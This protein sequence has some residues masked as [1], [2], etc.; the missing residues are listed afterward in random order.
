LNVLLVTL[1]TTRADHIQ[2]YGRRSA[3][4]PNLDRLAREGILFD[5]AASVAPLTVPAHASLLT[6]VLP[7]THGIRDNLDVLND[8]RQ[9]SLG[10][11]LKPHGFQTAAFIASRVIGAH[12]G[13]T[14]GFDLYDDV[15][16]QVGV[17]VARVLDPVIPGAFVQGRYAYGFSERQ[18]DISHNRSLLDL[19]MG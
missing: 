2:A 12:A 16:L 6:G 19:E 14:D 5:Q 1:D 15:D 8:R 13:L 9:P 4:T 10:R 3:D 7:S 18:L 11:V 17:Y